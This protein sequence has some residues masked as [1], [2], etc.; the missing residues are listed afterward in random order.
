MGGGRP[1]RRGGLYLQGTSWACC[2][3]PLCWH[4]CAIIGLGVV[5]LAVAIPVPVAIAV[6]VTIVVAIAALSSTAAF[7]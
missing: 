7:S 3:C 6:P 5:I 4:Q 2:P 1:K